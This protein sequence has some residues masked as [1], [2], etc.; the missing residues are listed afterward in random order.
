MKMLLVFA[1][2]FSVNCFAD[3]PQGHYVLD[4]IECSDGKVLKLGGK[5]MQYHITLDVT[6]HEMLMTA[7]ATSASWSP[8][9][10][11]CT[12]TNKGKFSYIGE[13]QYEGYLAMDVVD[14]NA[15]AWEAILKKQK[16][17][18][19]EQGIFDY[20]VNG[21][22]LVISNKETQTLYS[23]K[24]TGSIPVYHYTKK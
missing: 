9:K 7:K 4:K 10:L 12:Q 24:K 17:G 22:K 23:C 11:E 2:L 19:E 3:I 16:F 6:D 15:K 5:F 18:V 20:E 13:T 14:C 8:F 21:D 1:L